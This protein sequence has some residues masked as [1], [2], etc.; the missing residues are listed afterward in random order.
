VTVPVWFVISCWTTAWTRQPAIAA[1]TAF[2]PPRIVSSIVSVTIACWLAQTAL[3]AVT[4][5]FGPTL[6]PCVA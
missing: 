6:P 2:P 3:S 5:C 4:G 1:S